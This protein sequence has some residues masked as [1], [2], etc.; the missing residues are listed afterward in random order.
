MIPAL[1]MGFFAATLE[2]KLHKIV[3]DILDMLLVPFL[4]LLISLV[5]G[6]FVVGPV[7]S[8][9]EQALTDLILQM[10]TL[11]FGIGGVAYGGLI[12]ILC[13]VGMHH[14]VTPIIVSLYIH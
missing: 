1:F 11:P 3:P 5:A 9:V 8:G 10:L 12:Q 4:T 6:L 2:K 13:S 7:L 14:T